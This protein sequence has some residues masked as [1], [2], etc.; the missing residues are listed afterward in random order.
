MFMHWAHMRV[1]LINL[2]MTTQSLISL[3]LNHLT[4]TTGGSM[5]V[6]HFFNTV[7]QRHIVLSWVNETDMEELELQFLGFLGACQG[8]FGPFGLILISNPP[9]AEHAFL[10]QRHM[11]KRRGGYLFILGFFSMYDAIHGWMMGQMMRQMDG[12]KKLHE[13]QPQHPLLYVITKSSLVRI[14]PYK[15]CELLPSFTKQKPI[16]FILQLPSN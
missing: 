13:K 9:R 14:K 12:W 16:L 4:M 3:G 15:T 7:K 11:R 10:R 6:T 2:F 8:V 1:Q 5:Q